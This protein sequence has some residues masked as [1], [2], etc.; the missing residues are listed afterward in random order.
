MMTEVG[1]KF[2]IRKADL[3]RRM[4]EIYNLLPPIIQATTRKNSS[5][6]QAEYLLI[7]LR[8]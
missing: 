8:P 1:T 3:A 7:R 6:T 5:Q 2:V 4:L